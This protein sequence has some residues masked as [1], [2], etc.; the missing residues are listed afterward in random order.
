MKEIYFV[1]FR[2]DF[3][4]DSIVADDCVYKLHEASACLAD[5]LHFVHVFGFLLRW[6]FNCYFK[7]FFKSTYQIFKEKYLIKKIFF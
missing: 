4:E 3:S 6:I 2:F 5:T 7:V 1:F